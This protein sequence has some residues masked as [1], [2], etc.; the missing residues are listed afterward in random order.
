[1]N[2][3]LVHRLMARISDAEIARKLVEAGLD[4]PAKIR[5]ASDKE[6]RTALRGY[7]GIGKAVKLIRAA[8]GPR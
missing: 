4:Y 2:D 7:R 5:K 3:V 1:M 6:I 8:Y